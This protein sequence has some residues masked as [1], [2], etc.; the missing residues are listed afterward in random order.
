[1]IK[2]IN[3]FKEKSWTE[4]TKEDLVGMEESAN[5]YADQCIRLPKDL[6]EWKAYK[7]L[8]IR[9][10]NLRDVL[11]IIIDL[12]KPSILTRHWAKIAEITNTKLNYENSDQMTIEDL[13][14]ANLLNFTED[15]VDICE[16]A[17]KQM[18]IRAQ[19][20]EI[21]VYWDAAN[22]EFAV[23]G[24][25]DRPCMLQGLIVSTIKER[26]DDD[27][28]TLTTVNAQRHVTPFKVEVEL[29]IKTFAEVSDQL[30]LWVKVQKLWTSM[31]PVFTGG[32]IA[33]QMP[34]QAKQFQSI[35]KMW[36]KIMDKAVETKKVVPCC[37]NDILK[38][39]LPG[40]N[41]KLEDCQKM[42]EAYLEGKRKKFPR[43]YFVSNPTLLKILSQGSE[44][45]SIQ[46][47]FEKLFDAIN[48]V[49][50]DKN[51]EKKGSN[52]KMI[53]AIHAVMGRDEETVQLGLPVKCEG[54]I[55][56]WLKALEINMMSSLRDIS[57]AGCQKVFQVGLREFTWS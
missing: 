26:L 29:K 6:K 13:M 16:S 52:E 49:T 21:Q 33:R 9:I 15:I 41:E 11:P 1:V 55:E 27:Q 56:S 19:L 20:D 22:F 37:L 38:D 10:D 45:T 25:R 51:P 14:G 53:T 17:D 28:M 43:F 44:P 42:L 23:W 24:K 30:D 2:E 5:K 57:R 36:M 46:E 39:F 31:E 4:V 35:D 47:D 8:K 18:K 7:D 40:L 34:L 32:D 48:R 12:K 50:F 3:V 54:N